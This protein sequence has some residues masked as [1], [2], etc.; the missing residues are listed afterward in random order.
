MS[1][2]PI[3]ANANAEANASLESIRNRNIPVIQPF[4]GDKVMDA[5]QWLRIFERSTKRQ[6]VP[7]AEMVEE[8]IS[9]LIGAAEQWYTVY[10][11]HYCQNQGK[12]KPALWRKKILI[13]L[14]PSRLALVK[15]GP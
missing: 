2:E 12:L 7:E 9:Y 3:N 4:S 8:A 13:S 6:G 5:T 10:L 14:R 1:N 11:S 15:R